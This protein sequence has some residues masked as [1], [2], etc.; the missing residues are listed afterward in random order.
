MKTWILD[1]IAEPATLGLR[2][3]TAGSGGKLDLRPGNPALARP[4][5]HQLC[6]THPGVDY[7]TSWG[8]PECVR[9]LR[10]DNARLRAA[11]L[12]ALPFVLDGQLVSHQNSPRDPRQVSRESVAVQ[13][14]HVTGGA[15]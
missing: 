13:I 7:K 10:A 14:R 12:A 1:D 5:A 6:K 3:T 8:C 9:D 2:P 15:A 4:A 11:C